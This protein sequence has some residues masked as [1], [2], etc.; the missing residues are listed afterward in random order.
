V[1][2][3]YNCSNT[4]QHPATPVPSTEK[5]PS[6]TLSTFQ[7]TAT[8]CNTLQQPVLSA[9]LPSIGSGASPKTRV[10]KLQVFFWILNFIFGVHFCLSIGSSFSSFVL[11]HTLLQK[12]TFVATVASTRLV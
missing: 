11:E 8:R 3:F 1:Q 2:W 7:H 10:L 9:K 5:M 4:L 12:V 6:I